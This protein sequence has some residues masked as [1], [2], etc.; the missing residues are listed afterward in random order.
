M[1][2]FLYGG[3]SMR[4]RHTAALKH[5]VRSIFLLFILFAAVWSCVST[6]SSD[7]ASSSERRIILVGDSRTEG[8]HQY[9]GNKSGIIWSYKSSMGLTWMKSTGIPNI[10]SKIR[11]NTAVV[12]LMGVNDVLDLWQAD[13]YASYLNTKA[14]AWKKKGADTYYVS[15]P[16]VDDS[17]DKYEK[18]KNIKAWNTRIKGKLSANVTYVDIYSRMLSG[19]DTI[20]DGLHY[21]KSS[22]LKYFNLVYA[23]V[24]DPASTSSEQQ[25][26]EYYRLVYNYSDYL[27][28]NSDI[29]SKYRHDKDGAFQ[30]FLKTGMAEGRQA[31]KDFDPVSYRLEY[32]YV[33][34]AYK[35]DWKQYYLHYI[36]TGYAA[37]Y[38]GTGCEQMKHY[39]TVYNGVSYSR[40][41]N[42]NFYINLHPDLFKKYG[43]DEEAVLKHFV[44]VG[45]PRGYQACATFKYTAYKKYNKDL[46]AKFGTDRKQYY[47]H[48]IKE[49]YKEKRR[50]V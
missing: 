36:R 5:S 4:L 30:H 23:A 42:Y 13:N 3:L 24:K 17:K 1:L 43:Y 47:L 28:Y 35:D 50:A 2:I 14:S 37:K 49:G 33:R 19:L 10:E 22:S 48:Y 27:A 18:N 40:V 9:V 7:T 8:M 16:P 6:V 38:H 39:D 12:I 45:I 21:Q 32:K 46:A 26:E 20:S 41:Y 15:L 11:S 34:K 44:T 29:R 31:S 25:K